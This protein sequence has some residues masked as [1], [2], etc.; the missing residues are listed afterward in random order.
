MNSWYLH[1]LGGLREKG[2]KKQ[3]RISQIRSLCVI[4]IQIRIIITFHSVHELRIGSWCIFGVLEWNKEKIKIAPA[5]AVM[6]EPYLLIRKLT[7]IL[8]ED[9]KPGGT[10]RAV[11]Q[12]CTKRTAKICREQSYLDSFSLISKS[13]DVPRE[14][15]LNFSVCLTRSTTW[16]LEILQILQLG[17]RD[18]EWW[19]RDVYR[20]SLK[21]ISA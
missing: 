18:G 21:N 13:Q 7:F 19:E 1:C 9:E 8:F 16:L 11:V 4:V 10:V 20:T 3:I 17:V 5:E 15:K 6:I 12:S 2:F 14:Q